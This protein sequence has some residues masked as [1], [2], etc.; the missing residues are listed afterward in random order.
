LLDEIRFFCIAGTARLA[1]GHALHVFIDEKGD[2]LR[3]VQDFY[4]FGF[5]ALVAG[6]FASGENVCAVEI[7]GFVEEGWD[8]GVGEVAFYDGEGVEIAAGD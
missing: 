6:V 3:V 4:G 1:G 7:G 8:F 5:D 2:Y